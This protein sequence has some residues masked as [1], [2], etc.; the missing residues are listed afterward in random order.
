VAAVGDVAGKGRPVQTSR[1]KMSPAEKIASIR[2]AYD[3]FN[4]RD[5]AKVEERYAEDI[6][7]HFATGDVRGRKNVV[8]YAKDQVERLGAKLEP[9]DILANDQHAVAL[10]SYVA[11]GK[12]YKLTHVTHIDDDGRVTEAW[13]FGE[14]EL[15]KLVQ[16]K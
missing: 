6:V 13:S 8:A 1:T 7:W 14:P 10:L 12:T 4:K 5:Y 16:S 2:A 11:K 15:T 3:A 9:H